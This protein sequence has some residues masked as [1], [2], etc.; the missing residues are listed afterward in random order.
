MT[1]TVT[2]RAGTA[3][4]TATVQVRV[5]QYVGA[6]CSLVN[7]CPTSVSSWMGIGQA[8]FGGALCSNKMFYS[9]TQTMN[10][11]QSG[12][13]KTDNESAIPPH[14]LVVITF[15]DGQIPSL[16]SYVS[17][18]P[19]GRPVWMCYWQEAEDSFPNGDYKTFVANFIKAAKAIRSVGNPNVK[20]LQNCAGYQ[21]GVN[22]STAAQGL[23]VVDP[24]WVDFYSID[25]YQN[26]AAGN[27]P[28]Q[29]L[30]NYPEFQNWLKIFAGRGRPL[31][32]TEYGVNACN[33]DA[34]RN[35]RIQ[36]DCAYLRQAFY[37][38]HPVSPFPLA[39]WQYWWSNCS[40]GVL[41]TSC[42]KQ[43]QFTDAAT[44]STWWQ[45][46]TGAL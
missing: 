45:I 34:A 5:A 15:K 26:Q 1:D 12:H 13:L 25:C 29:G 32:I 7:D 31:G 40:A 44:I 8:T 6:M 43:H 42:T 24:E 35:I 22:G 10:T 4:I 33:G 14:S 18:I 2:I 28:S 19:P 46:C 27:W 23:W 3:N 38:P 20:I 11:W 21:Y 36:Q 37:G 17:S 9:G 30:A 39:L 41:Q 16:P